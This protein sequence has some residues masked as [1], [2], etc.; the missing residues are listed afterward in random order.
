MQHLIQ[1][2][3]VP[4]LS[5]FSRDLYR[6]VATRWTG[7]GLGYLF[8]LLCFICI[9]MT[10]QVA[11]AIEQIKVVYMQHVIDKLPPLQIEQG[12]LTTDV[13]QPYVI[14]LPEM[15]E[16]FLVIDTRGTPAGEDEF[17]APVV[18]QADR[19][20]IDNQ[21][22]VRSYP[23]EHISQF[24]LNKAELSAWVDTMM[25]Y[26]KLLAYVPLLVSEF[27]YRA[28]QVVI[29][30]VGGLVFA[31]WLKVRLPY[32]VLLRLTCVALTPSL[33]LGLL[34]SG[35]GLNYGLMSLVL[36]LVSQGYIF[37]AIQS[38]ARQPG[39]SSPDDILVV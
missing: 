38:V 20:I 37:F 24:T 27:I 12:V 26:V 10:F 16:P 17:Q 39:N 30:A 29:Y 33:L 14:R 36:F 11:P 25:G 21:G 23:F 32:G 2:W 34:V 13:Q 8:L 6:D 15:D 3:H 28:L 9:P 4:Y 19:M 7:S 18:L 1:K 35:L 5:F 22:E 31:A